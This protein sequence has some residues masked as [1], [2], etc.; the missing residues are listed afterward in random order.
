MVTIQRL[1]RQSIWRIGSTFIKPSVD[2]SGEMSGRLP[3]KAMLFRHDELRDRSAMPVAGT[4][5]IDR[6][7]PAA[8]RLPSE[9]RH[10]HERKRRAD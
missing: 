9:L 1:E 2:G 3:A 6:C 8:E 4:L 7:R 5:G 10:D